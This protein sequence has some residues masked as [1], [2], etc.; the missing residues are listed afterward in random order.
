MIPVTVTDAEALIVSYLEAR[1]V[2]MIKGSP[3][4]GKSAIV[5]KVAESLGLKLIDIRLAQCDPT[6]LLG[7]PY[8]DKEEGRARYMP[9]DIFPLA[10]DP[11]PKGYDGWLV[12]MDELNAADRAVQKA[13][14]K[15]LLDRM[16]GNHLI[17]ERVAMAAA[18][19]MDT[20]S[21]LVEELSSALQSRLVHIEV[22]SDAPS[23]CEWATR[24]GIDHRIISFMKFAPNRM[25]TFNPEKQGDEPTY[26]CERTWEMAHKLLSKGLDPRNKSALNLLT[27]VLGEGAAR[28]F[29]AYLKVFK[30]L[31]TIEEIIK[32]P[33]AIKV[34]TEPG[35][36]FAITGTIGHNVNLGNV[37][38]L[39][40]FVARLPKEFQTV[41]LRYI[42]AKDVSLIHTSSA[43][44]DW[45]ASNNA[46]LF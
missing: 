39:M 30:D 6:D 21:A 34:P 24:S 45:I 13:A 33:N 26:A 4:L 27:G 40:E 14:Y 43:I 19:N 8:I 32:S 42:A 35:T 18:G 46:D 15:P 23:W 7:F 10:G 41:C 37:D 5:K 36:L 28:E 1:L 25:N 20:D 9:M 31:P 38:Q 12:F 16:I 44:K 3:G 22:K 29:I 17:H 11:V 2:P